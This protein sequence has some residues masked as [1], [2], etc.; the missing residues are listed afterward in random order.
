M[1]LWRQLRSPGTALLLVALGF[2]L[3]RSDTQPSV[4]V[5]VGTSASIVPGDVAAVVLI[6]AAA[7][8][9]A[10]HG[11]PRPARP[12]LASGA[13][14]CL[15]VLATGAV[16]GA[17]SLVAGAKMVEL[18]ALALGAIAF[19]HSRAALEAV[20]DV[21]L[22]AT[23]AADVW[24]GVEFLRAGGGRQA[25][26]LG[27]HELA[28][29]GTL[30]L[31]YGLVLVQSRRRH[32]RAALSIVAGSLACILGA[33]LATLLGLWLAAA[34]FLA[35][36]VLRR[37]LSRRT[38]AVTAVTVALVTGGTAEIRS[39]AFGFLQVLAGHHE[40]RPA[41]F[42]GSWSQRLIYTYIGGRV[43]LAHPALGTGWY[44]LLPPREWTP[45]LPDAKRRFADQPAG[46]FPHPDRPL[47]PQQTYDQVLSQL[48]AVGFAVFLALLLSVAAAAWRAARRAPG[49]VGDL[50]AAWFAGGLG[51]IAGEALFGGSPL[52]ALWWL[53][54]GTAA[55]LATI[56]AT[57]E[58]EPA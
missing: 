14:F 7:W 50:P 35:T 13:A 48:G 52:A 26:F 32:G 4:A 28:A 22:I 11:V 21:L 31:V 15:L 54:V 55:A 37:S 17:S 2:T 24:A 46:Y 9:L 34:V 57:P 19:L 6:L 33:S 43:F 3:V 30:P 58:P 20:V 49:V 38:L 18:A 12:V 1:Q 10:R 16:N 45:F 40:S 5:Q 27:E 53:A 51:A 23:L 36:L 47:I 56:A 39:G 25:A 44:S 29:L 8:A 41:E 42:A